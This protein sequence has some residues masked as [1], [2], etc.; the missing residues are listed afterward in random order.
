MRFG[1]YPAMK[2]VNAYIKARVRSR[3]AERLRIS[4]DSP[5]VSSR[6]AVTTASR[7]RRNF[8]RDGWVVMLTRERVLQPSCRAPFQYASVA[9]AHVVES[10]LCLRRVAASAFSEMESDCDRCVGRRSHAVQDGE[11]REQLG[12]ACQS[13]RRRSCISQSRMR[14]TVCRRPRVCADALTVRQAFGFGLWSSGLV[15]ARA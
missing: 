1:K 2:N 15:R 7:G 6:V 13:R 9:D 5:G 4:A 8:S 3:R 14:G 12:P 10:G 11:T